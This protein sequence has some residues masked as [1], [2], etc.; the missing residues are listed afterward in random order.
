MALQ[1]GVDHAEDAFFMEG[2]EIFEKNQYGDATWRRPCRG[3][4]FY[5]GIRD[6]REK[7][8]WRRNMAPTMPRMHFLWRN[9]SR[10]AVCYPTFV[11]QETIIAKNSFSRHNH[12][13]V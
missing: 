5:G 4:I 1:H 8:T 10:T 12:H 11:F 9:L 6:F 2:Y 3:C 7:S 13:R